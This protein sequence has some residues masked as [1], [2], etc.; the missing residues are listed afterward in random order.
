MEQ[1]TIQTSLGEIQVTV[2]HSTWIFVR[3]KKLTVNGVEYR[4]YAYLKPND[5]DP[6]ALGPVPTTAWIMDDCHSHSPN[7]DRIQYRGKHQDYTQ[8]ARKK[9]TKV[10]CEVISRWIKAHPAIPVKAQ[11]DSLRTTVQSALN[12]IERIEGELKE[13]KDDHFAALEALRKHENTYKEV[14]SG[15]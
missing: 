9:V 7:L 1:I 6:D 13:A 15:K 8:A 5:V 4:G 12:K 10:L 3:Y 14:L 11:Y 2:N